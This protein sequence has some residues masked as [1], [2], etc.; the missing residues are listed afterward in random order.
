MLRLQF[1]DTTYAFSL[2]IREEKAA[3]REAKKQAMKNAQET[4]IEKYDTSTGRFDDSVS[5]TNQKK[6][7]YVN[8]FRKY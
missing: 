4:I 3:Q 8:R 2:D 6:R 7:N 1:C 5:Y